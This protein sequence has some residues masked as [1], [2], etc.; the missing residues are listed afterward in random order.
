M[1]IAGEERH[2]SVAGELFIGQSRARARA[3]FQAHH[4]SLGEALKLV[5]GAAGAFKI[6]RASAAACHLPSP[7][8]LASAS[9]QGT[10]P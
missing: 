1:T 5:F 2:V 8:P 3:I 4:P 9:T 10:A 7:L 6:K